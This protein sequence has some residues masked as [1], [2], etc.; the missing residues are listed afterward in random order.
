MGIDPGLARLGWGF[1]EPTVQPQVRFG[2][3]ETEA[4]GTLS[5]RLMIVYDELEKLFETHRP[6]V[7][8]IETLFFAKNAKALAQVG[9]ARGVILLV[10]ARFKV[11]VFEYAPKQ[12]KLA[13]T[14]FGGAEKPQM[15]AM[16][17]R[18]LNLSSMPTPDDAADA[19]AV[20]LCHAQYS[21][22]LG[23]SAVTV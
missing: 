13:L 4:G 14:G 20:A 3:I 16:V 15:Q 18:L 23:K 19:V 7:L 6:D 21:Q 22:S 2:C 9:H 12:I 5:E 11:R 10:A 1:I 8:A 17:K